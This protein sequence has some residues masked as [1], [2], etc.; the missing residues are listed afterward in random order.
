MMFVTYPNS[1]LMRSLRFCKSVIRALYKPVIRYPH[2]KG[3][4]GLC[5]VSV[6]ARVWGMNFEPSLPNQRSENVA[7]RKERMLSPQW[8]DALVCLMT[9][10]LEYP[11]LKFF[12]RKIDTQWT[13]LFI[14]LWADYARIDANCWF[15]ES[16]DFT[17]PLTV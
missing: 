11:L 3:S 7:L 6:E 1:C 10:E 13:F 9:V 14:S 15:S 4:K 2:K 17:N 12:T 16:Y 5:P 8:A